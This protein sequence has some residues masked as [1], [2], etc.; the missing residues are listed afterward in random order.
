MPLQA[1]MDDSGNTPHGG[2]SHQDRF[3]LA[4]FVATAAKWEIFS[5]QWVEVLNRA[6]KIEYFKMNALEDGNAPFVTEFGMTVAREFRLQKMNELT[7]VILNLEPLPVVVSLKWEEYECIARGNVHPKIDSPYAVLFYQAMR[8]VHEFEIIVNRLYPE[9]NFGFLPV[10]FIFD[11]QGQIGL[12]ALQ[13]YARLADVVPEP[14]K[15]MIGNT[16]VF[17]NDRDMVPLQAAD[18]LAWHI[19]RAYAYPQEKLPF[20]RRIAT[21]SD[22]IHI[23]EVGENALRQFVELNKQADPDEL[24]KGF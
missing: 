2:A 4:G 23:N 20:L 16:P 6:P 10:D 17:R 12:Q 15:T 8:Y 7:E 1:Y 24:A 9:R 14:Y 5:N 19:R 11:E 3:V 22:G 18:M 13:W 21:A